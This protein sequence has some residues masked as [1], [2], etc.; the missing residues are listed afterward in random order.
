[1]I[2]QMTHSSEENQ[3]LVAGYIRYR[4]SLGSGGAPLPP[5]ASPAE[6]E[7]HDAVDEILRNGP[8]A[9]AWE[10]ALAILSEM[11]E[12]KLGDYAVGPLETLVARWGDV[13]VEEIER[14][15]ARD[16]RFRWALGVIW[17]TELGFSRTPAEREA[18]V[19]IVAASGGRLKVLEWVQKSKNQ[20]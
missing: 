11:P 13:L 5:R 7:A 20:S 14:E 6:K 18:L 1:M 15:A 10:L 17:L 8:P 4:D 2:R 3:R 12:E 16:A 19:R 9:R